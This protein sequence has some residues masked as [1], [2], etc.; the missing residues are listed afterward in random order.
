ME[1]DS[2]EATVTIWVRGSSS[3]DGV[4]SGVDGDKWWNS[5][6]TLNLE[7]AGLVDGWDCG[8]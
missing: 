1:T 4:G 3:L 8:L 5:G 2:F 7:F 6:Y